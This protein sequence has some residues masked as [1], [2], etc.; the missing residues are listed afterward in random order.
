L[1]RWEGEKKVRRWEGEKVGRW[2]AK[3]LKAFVAILSVIS[4]LGVQA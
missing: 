1:G 3:K 4:G 2:E